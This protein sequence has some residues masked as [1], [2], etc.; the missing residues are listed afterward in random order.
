MLGFLKINAMSVRDSEEADARSSEELRNQDGL[1]K[2]LSRLTIFWTMK[3]LP[4]SVANFSRKI[5]F[6]ESGL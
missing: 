3:S 2:A 6:R 1:E 5:L 4:E